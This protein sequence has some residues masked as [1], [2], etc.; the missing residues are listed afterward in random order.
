MAKADRLARLDG[1]RSELEAEY[2]AALIYALQVAVSGKWGLFDRNGDRWTRA[3]VRPVVDNLFEIGH[4]IDR[5]REQLAMLPFDLH[6][7][8]LASR[9]PVGPEAV[10]EQKQAQEWLSRL[11]PV[12]GDGGG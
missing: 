8:F 9:G 4:A 3:A 6:R 2:T 5:M 11:A 10:G 1:R 12:R 7:E